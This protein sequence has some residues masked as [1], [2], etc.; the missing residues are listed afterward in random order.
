VQIRAV[1]TDHQDAREVEILQ[2]KAAA[3]L[4]PGR[5]PVAMN[6]EI[7]LCRVR[8]VP[9]HPQTPTPSSGTVPSSGPL[10]LLSLRDALSVCQ[11]P[12]RHIHAC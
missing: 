5:S 2:G 6:E 4:V 8:K 11:T 12:L 10:P 9:Q 1:R 7:Y 3:H